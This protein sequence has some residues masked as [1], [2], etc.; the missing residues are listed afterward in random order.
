MFNFYLRYDNDT[1]NPIILVNLAYISFQLANLLNVKR[2]RVF[3]FFLVVYFSNE[4]V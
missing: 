2:K 3:F 1:V 4:D